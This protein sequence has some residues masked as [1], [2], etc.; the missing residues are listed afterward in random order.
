MPSA[1]SPSPVDQA[2]LILAA[3]QALPSPVAI[4]DGATVI[5]AVNNA[6]RRAVSDNGEWDSSEP[7]GRPYL[8]A[9]QG[10][11]GPGED[12][13]ATVSTG[14]RQVLEGKAP[15]FARSY[16]CG[17]NLDDRAFQMVAS[18]LPAPGG[19][20]VVHQELT[21]SSA[22][23]RIRARRAREQEEA[24]PRL[25]EHAPVLM[26]TTDAEQRP[27]WFNRR[28]L[29][30][31]GLSL[32]QALAD[33]WRLRIHPD[34]RAAAEAVADE[35]RQHR[36][37]Y[38]RKFRFQRGDGGYRWLQERGQPLY[39]ADRRFAGYIGSCSDITEIVRTEEDLARHRDHL[40]RQLHFAEIL[41]RMAQAIGGMD[42]HE[43]VL[44]TLAA[45]LGRA[46]GLDRCMIF[47]VRL[48][49]RMAAGI[50][51]WL[52]P[53]SPRSLSAKQD[54]PLDLFA[55]S[56]RFLWERRSSLESHRDQP[57]P[58]LVSEGSAALLHERLDVASLLWH[59]F[60]F[61][62]EGFHL[63]VL[64]QVDR[65]RD[66][67]E[68]ERRFIDAVASQVALALQKLR[69]LARQR[70]A[71]AQLQQ[72]RKMDTMGR[73]A[74]DVAHDFNNLLTAINGHAH[75]LGS[76][77]DGNDSARHHLA[78]ILQATDR[79]AVTTRQLLAFSRRQE[80][81]PRVVQPNSVV[82]ELRK[83]I[84]RLLPANI[85]L[86]TPLDPEAGLVHADPT[87]LELVLMNLAINARD[88]MPHGGT[89]TITSGNV[90]LDGELAQQQRLGPGEYVEL[91]VRDTGI[92]MDPATLERIFEPFFTTKP[93]TGT[94][95]G[96]S[97]AYGLIAAMGG[98]L[99]VASQPTR[100]S[101]FT[102]HLP[103]V[104]AEDPNQTPTPLRLPAAGGNET[105]LLVEDDPS[106]LSLARESL[107]HH[108]YHV[109][110]ADD[111]ESALRLAA[112]HPGAIDLLLS[113]LMLPRLGGNELAIKLRSQ[114]PAVRVV[115]ISGY[116][117]DA[118]ASA[119]DLPHAG[120]LAK[121]FTIDELMRAVRVAI[122]ARKG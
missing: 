100:G 49:Q 91:S 87:Q 55:E 114:R 111:A 102:I 67:P 89:L 17:S 112:H 27:L 77:V 40:H 20:V 24:L 103:R 64:N 83:L 52:N 81:R 7:V 110:A 118:F 106:V 96:L 54:F 92:G 121:P 28:W 26:W 13:H 22:S 61:H 16:V 108:G 19:V 23:G 1:P 8:E 5:V 65:R 99:T 72:V 14:L 25:A 120:F 88:A 90:L 34:D 82:F 12:Q 119:R 48:P 86:E 42:S 58:R 39:H 62:Q 50:S 10:A 21:P 117:A 70:A 18:A 46:L 93:G 73:L 116:S 36:R 66:W 31:T 32:E 57:N 105:V 85:T 107:Q 76:Q 35:A 74:G 94:G 78:A 59:P 98:A 80:L 11:D 95:L 69:I 71:E 79:A 41:N 6:W 43:A 63:L 45:L 101:A 3:F 122:D 51:E 29:D 109:L 68:D 47:D 15:R 84:G 75:L 38:L 56:L 113:D 37:E 30:F 97:S 60:G 53:D 4:L 115:F 44:D 2:A 33:D 104:L 9:C